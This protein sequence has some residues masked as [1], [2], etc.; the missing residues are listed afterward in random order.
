MTVPLICE[1]CGRVAGQREVYCGACGRP[2]PGRE[3]DPSDAAPPGWLVTPTPRDG[4]GPVFEPLPSLPVR[5]ARDS[6]PGAEKGGAP[7]ATPAAPFTPEAA[8]APVAA[9]PVEDVHTVVAAAAAA[10]VAEQDAHRPLRA[11]YV[12]LLAICLA[13]S[14]GAVTLLVLHALLHR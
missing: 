10:L 13:S 1:G 12:P 9:A 14:A 3:A 7:E 6:W 4:T 8:A 5:A 2:L 11:L